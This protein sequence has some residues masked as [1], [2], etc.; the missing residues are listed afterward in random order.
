[1]KRRKNAAKYSTN[2]ELLTLFQLNTT[3]CH[4]VDKNDFSSPCTK[5]K[6]FCQ[7]RVY[8]SAKMWKIFV[9]FSVVGNEGRLKACGQGKTLLKRAFP[10][11]R[12]PIPIS[13]TF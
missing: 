12:A 4:Y 2:T 3:S 8:N 6:S 5:E 11:P 9:P 7:F 13:K 10:F 1:M